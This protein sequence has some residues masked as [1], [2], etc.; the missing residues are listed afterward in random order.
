LTEARAVLGQI[1][2]RLKFTPDTVGSS[3]AAA[4]RKQRQ[5]RRLRKGCRARLCAPQGSK[6]IPAK[7]VEFRGRTR[8]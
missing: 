1:A 2:K 4:A 8:A 5:R 6:E 3:I 7:T